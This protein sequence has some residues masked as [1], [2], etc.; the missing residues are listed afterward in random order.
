MCNTDDREKKL[1]VVRLKSEK[2]LDVV[3]F[4]I[5]LLL[6]FL[7]TC[8]K[9]LTDFDMADVM[10]IW[11]QKP[12]LGYANF[13]EGEKETVFVPTTSVTYTDTCAR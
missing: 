1:C 4:R 9:N 5:F 7:V 12:Y 6:G 11:L 2:K 8:F 13:P 10:L 3:S